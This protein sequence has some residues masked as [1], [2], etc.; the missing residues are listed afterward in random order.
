VFG[1]AGEEIEALRVAGIRVEVIPGITAASAAAAMLGRSLTERQLA[2]R[3]QFVTAHSREGR[4]P[5]NLDWRALADPEATTVIYMGVRTLPELVL[6][7]LGA[8]LPPDT[9]AVIVER[10]S[11]PGERCCFGTIAELPELAKQADVRAPSL[12]MIGSVFRQ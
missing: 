2:R 4:L 11:W 12:T 9:P 10:V 8:G 7:L 5:D 3:L 1:R 6:R